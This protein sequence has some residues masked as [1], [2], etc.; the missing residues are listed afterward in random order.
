MAKKSKEEHISTETK[1]YIDF[2]KEPLEELENN[3]RKSKE[4]TEQLDKFIQDLTKSPSRGA[5]QRLM[6]AFETIVELQ[7]QKQQNIKEI[8]NIRKSILDYTFKEKGD[9][10]SDFYQLYNEM[11][12]LV[13]LPREEI[14]IENQNPD[15]INAIISK[16]FGKSSDK[17]TPDDDSSNLKTEA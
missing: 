1:A 15:E 2:F 7:S 8:F 4:Y 9:D 6:E 11:K 13:K 3:L 10:A 17:N 14:V 12:A 16:K 5:P